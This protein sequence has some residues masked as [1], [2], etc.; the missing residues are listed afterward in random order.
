MAN[1]IVEC[2]SGLRMHRSPEPMFRL[3][4]DQDRECADTELTGIQTLPVLRDPR[5]KHQPLTWW[6]RWGHI[7]VSKLHGSTYCVPTKLCYCALA[8]CLEGYAYLYRG[9]GSGQENFK[10]AGALSVPFFLR[11]RQ[12]QA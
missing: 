8:D 9:R 4:V 6:W 10:G 5:K 7:D 3:F 2:R 11:E 1:V 12:T